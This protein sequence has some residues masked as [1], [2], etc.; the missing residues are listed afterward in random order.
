MFRTQLVTSQFFYLLLFL[1]L[2]SAVPSPDLY[3]AQSQ[4]AGTPEDSSPPPNMTLIPAGEFM[5]G[6]DDDHDHS[7]AHRVQ[8]S[9]FYMDT[10]EVTSAQYLAFCEATDR[11]LPM[12]W[13]IEKFRCGPDYPDHPVVGVSSADAAAYA[14]WAGKR[15]PTEAEWEYAARGG[16]EGLEYGS[17]ADVDSSL[18]NYKSKA[19]QPVGN[20]PANGYGLHDM[21]GNVREWVADYYTPDYYENSPTADPQ[22]PDQTNYR[23]VRGGGW[24]SGK[25]CN[26]VHTRLAL[27]VYW[28]DFNIGFRCAK[29]VS[30]SV[31]GDE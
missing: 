12:F 3:A 25:S 21:V 14:E 31:E 24:F 9:A 23:V 8:L 13:G 28:V 27:P 18:A 17:E 19:T 2:P 6:K 5:M 20:Y 1:V 30:E 16:Q 15:L 7:P 29:S 4:Q 22:G 11:K 26:R 10:H